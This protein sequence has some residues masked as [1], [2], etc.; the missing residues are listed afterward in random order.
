MEIHVLRIGK[1]GVYLGCNSGVCFIL[2]LTQMIYSEK[3]F[4]VNEY[5]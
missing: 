5:L 3:N 4:L 1:C 2:N